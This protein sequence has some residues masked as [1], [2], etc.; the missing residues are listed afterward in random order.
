MKRIDLSPVSMA[1]VYHSSLEEK[2]NTTLNMTRR[3]KYYD[4]GRCRFGD[5]CWNL[6][7]DG[8]QSGSGGGQRIRRCLFF[9]RGHCRYG[10]HCRFAHVGSGEGVANHGFATYDE[11]GC[12]A[13]VSTELE[14][15][16]VNKFGGTRIGNDLPEKVETLANEVYQSLGAGWKEYQYQKALA[17]KI[18][19]LGYE[20]MEEKTLQNAK[21]YFGKG[22]RVDIYV[23]YGSDTESAIIELKAVKKLTLKH[24]EQIAT[25][26]EIERRNEHPVQYGLLINF[27]TSPTTNFGRNV[28]FSQ[29]WGYWTNKVRTY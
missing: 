3:C 6:H 24:H 2:N 15:D 1:K 28:E 19:D 25:Y 8:G 13:P 26:L 9:D 22:C 4:Q 23:N 11:D 21:L 12:Y 20:V 7:I 16:L 27:P 18:R 14:D 5:G 29:G 10:N 17:N